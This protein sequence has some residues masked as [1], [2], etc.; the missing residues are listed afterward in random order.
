MWKVRVV[1]KLRT[2]GPGEDGLSEGDLDVGHMKLGENLFAANGGGHGVIARERSW[3]DANPERE[4]TRS[5]SDFGE[6]D[7]VN[8][9][10]LYVDAIKIRYS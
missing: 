9:R 6:T 5:V 10:P 4:W 7:R 2:G 1:E 3:H 8:R